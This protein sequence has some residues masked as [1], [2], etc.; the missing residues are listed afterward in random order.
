MPTPVATTKIILMEI[1]N[2]IIAIIWIWLEQQK[3]RKLIKLYWIFL[4]FCL[5]KLK[6]SFEDDLS[7]YFHF[8]KHWTEVPL[9]FFND[10]LCQYMT[11]YWTKSTVKGD[12]SFNEISYYIKYTKFNFDEEHQMENKNAVK[13]ELYRDA[14]NIYKFQQRP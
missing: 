9:S 2:K 14:S 8:A 6:V 10:V 13:S 7:Y 12:Q 3:S 11:N 1:G 4:K 5:R